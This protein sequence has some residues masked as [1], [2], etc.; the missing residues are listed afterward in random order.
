MVA[1]VRYGVMGPDCA[2][3]TVHECAA[4]LGLQLENDLRGDTLIVTAMP[5]GV[6]RDVLMAVFSEFGEIEHAAVASNMRGFGELYES[7]ASCN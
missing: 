4:L 6:Q 2:S 5:K 1:S 3:R 7:F